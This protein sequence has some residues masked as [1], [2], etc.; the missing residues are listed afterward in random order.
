MKRREQVLSEINKKQE[1]VEVKSEGMEMR[2]VEDGG[3]VQGQKRG[4]FNRSSLLSRHGFFFMNSQR[5]S[6][7]FKE[8]LISFTG[9]K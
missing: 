6:F 1:K 2:D 3:K 5:V 8:Y 4:F 7:S 9:E